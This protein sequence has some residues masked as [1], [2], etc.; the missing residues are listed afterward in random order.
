MCI[1]DLKTWKYN[2]KWQAQVGREP[3]GKSNNMVAMEINVILAF[4]NTNSSSADRD[5][6]TLAQL[7]S[8]SLVQGRLKGIWM[9]AEKVR[10]G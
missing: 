2:Q 9:A 5:L 10:I 1:V 4:N 3:C 8:W 6:A 7:T